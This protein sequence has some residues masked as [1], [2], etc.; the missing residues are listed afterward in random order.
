MQ[1]A[2]SFDVEDYFQVSAFAKAVRFEDWP[3]FE[4]RVE[5]STRRIL[6]ILDAAK[7]K[8]TFFVL[9]WVAEEQPEIVREIARFGG[10]VSMFVHPAVNRRLKAKAA[11]LA[12]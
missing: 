11:G 5:A 7:T 9:G 8:A 2:L 12:R 1:N 10:D 6:D 3:R 4:S